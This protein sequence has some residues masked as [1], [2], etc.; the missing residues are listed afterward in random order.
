[1]L[2][3]SSHQAAF[4]GGSSPT[5]TAPSSTG[6]SLAGPVGVVE[7]FPVDLGDPGEHGRGLGLVQ[8]GA[9]PHQHHRLA[10]AWR[11]KNPSGIAPTSTSMSPPDILGASHTGP[12]NHPLQLQPP[13]GSEMTSKG[14]HHDRLDELG[15]IYDAQVAK[16]DQCHAAFGRP[17]RQGLHRHRGIAWLGAQ[18]AQRR[19]PAAGA[20][21]PV[22]GQLH[23]DFAHPRLGQI[24]G[25]Q[26]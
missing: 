21:E 12:V 15:G 4:R 24:V 23:G 1:M 20:L 2:P 17:P 7:H 22:G 25:P 16:Q 3:H 6:T 26:A 11:L 13:E 10:P 18:R 14:N 5:V 19:G 8:V 9:S